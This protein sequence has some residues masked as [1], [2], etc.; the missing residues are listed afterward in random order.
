MAAT[1]T[2]PESG[3]KVRM[4][5]VGFG[6]C[7]LLAFR[8]Q[9]GDPFYMLIDCGST[10]VDKV[11]LQEVVT[12]IASAT[13]GHLHI[14]AATHEHKDHMNGF[15]SA[16]SV[17]EGIEVHKIWLA[18]TENITGEDAD[19]DARKL[20]EKYEKQVQ[21]LSVVGKRLKSLRSPLAAPVSNSL[22][23]HPPAVALAGVRAVVYMNQLGPTLK[24]S[25]FVYSDPAKAPIEIPEI[26]GVRFYTLGPP[27]NELKE[28][29][30][31]VDQPG[32]R[33]GLAGFSLAVLS[34]Y[35]DKEA[36]KDI[37][38]TVGT[39][40]PFDD[41]LGM[42]QK[43][44]DK[45]R[46]GGKAFF[47]KHYGSKEDSEK[48]WR[49]IDNDWL[50]SA[51]ELALYMD[52]YFNDTSLVL[53]IELE[54]SG[55]VLLFPGDAQELNLGSWKNTE[56]NVEGKKVNG[57]DLISRTAFYKVGHHCSD[58]ATDPD[59]LKKMRS[60]L[61]AMIPIDGVWGG[62]EHGLPDEKTLGLLEAKVGC[63][64]RADQIPPKP[65]EKC[66]PGWDGFVPPL[67][68]DPTGK[69]LWIEYTI[70]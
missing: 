53:A 26:P 44:A 25:S 15:Y 41:S 14:V 39:G 33:S 5:N 21:A 43:E 11:R 52:G 37:H 50:Q 10:S 58:N 68:H 36:R 65:E 29:A 62:K 24:C 48:D 47:H 51:G 49:R 55:K 22:C 42:S 45:Y 6:D 70:A 4:Y 63:P 61:V 34:A 38:D 35:G 1:M 17:F 2:A 32:M 9:K 18:W 64:I 30:G 13:G 56:W 57:M 67:A 19:P 46:I 69:K 28:K 60:D 23:M 12:D 40:R 66:E 54:E 27:R 3:V 16:Q 59:Y 31:I 7:F 20:N 8:D